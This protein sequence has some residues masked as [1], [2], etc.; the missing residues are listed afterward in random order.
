MCQLRG[1]FDLQ[2]S[3][4]I[5]SWR[6]IWGVVYREGSYSDGDAD[7]RSTIGTHLAE[8]AQP[9]SS[10]YEERQTKERE[11][12]V[13]IHRELWSCLTSGRRSSPV[14]DSEALTSGH[15]SNRRLPWILT[16]PNKAVRV[17]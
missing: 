6:G 1:L 2:L 14:L 15:P 9:T 11:T 17:K 16:A 8:K 4:A 3:S 10:I 12:S 5:G 7:A 13:I